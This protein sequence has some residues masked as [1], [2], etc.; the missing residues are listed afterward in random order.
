M[1]EPVKWIHGVE[2][3]R[4]VEFAMGAALPLRSH[5]FD[6]YQIVVCLVNDRC[7][8]LE[9]SIPIM[10]MLI[11]SITLLPH[12]GLNLA[13][14]FSI[15]TGERDLTEQ[16]K[17]MFKLVKKALG[18]SILSITNPTVKVATQILVGKVMRKC[19]T[20]E[21]RTPV[22]SLAAHCVKRVQFNWACCLCSEFL[23]NKG[24]HR[25]T[26]KDFITHGFYFRLCW[27]HGS[28]W[29]TVNFLQS[30]KIYQK[31][32]SFLHYG[33]RR[34]LSGSAR[35]RYSRYWRKWASI[36]PSI[37]RKGCHQQPS[38]SC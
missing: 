21:V 27:S 31:Q 28:C 5:K 36:W 16:M 11:H 33:P 20:D 19:H 38:S 35:E 3:A 9:D 14:E 37:T 26:T 24:R 8:W 32:R 10:D 25:T 13:K 17:D 15:K 18:Y 23:T 22:I 12:S 29:R 4:F 7:L 6:I 34:T 30:W 1:L 2:K